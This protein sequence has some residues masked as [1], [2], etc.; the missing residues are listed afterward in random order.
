[1]QP[2]AAVAHAQVG[3]ELTQPGR[4]QGLAAGQAN[5]LLV[6]ALAQ[7]EHTPAVLGVALVEALV[8]QPHAGIGGPV[9]VIDARLQRRDAAGE[10]HLGQAL[11]RRREVAQRA[12][13]AE[14]LAEDAR[15]LAA[16]LAADALGVGDDRVG[17]EVGQ[18]VGLLGRGALQLR[19]DRARAPGAAL[20]EQKHAEVG[21]G[22]LEP[23]RRRVRPRGPRGLRA[24]AALEEEEQ[25]A[26]LPL[27]SR[28]LAGE[29]AQPLAARV[30][31]IERQRVLA[32][33]H[34]QAGNLA[35][36]AHRRRG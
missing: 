19:A 31:V 5:R 1:M 34:D 24:R 26:L 12:E 17:A 11:G 2:V 3:A 27:W 15:A 23:R 30:G 16:E 18:V 10:E 8:A 14:A 7:R 6:Q 28:Q 22:P 33:G 4:V 25:R 35:A 20:I 36:D 9:D 21:Q 32:L 13:A 29:D